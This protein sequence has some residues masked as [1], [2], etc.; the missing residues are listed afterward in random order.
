MEIRGNEIERMGG[1]EWVVANGTGGFALGTVSGERMRGYHGLLIAA[2][3]PPLGRMMLV[4]GVR[5]TVVAGGAQFPLYT[6]RYGDGRS[7]PGGN[8][9]IERFRM[10][11]GLPVWT[12][13]AGG[14]LVEK[15][16]G[17][18]RDAAAAF[19]RWTLIEGDG[20]DLEIRVLVA[21]RGYH[22]VSSGTERAPR[23]ETGPDRLLV[24]F[25]DA[26]PPLA[27]LAPRA[28][29][30]E[31]NVEWER[32]LHLA[33]EEYRGL[34]C[35]EDIPSV[36]P[37]RF[38]IERGGRADLI[39]SAEE[40]VD[41]DVD[42][43]IR[44][45]RD[46]DRDLMERGASLI[47]SAGE[48]AEEIRALLRA[49]DSFLAR[50]PTPDDPDG[51][52]VIAGYPWFTD[53][54]RDTMIALPGLA[55]ATGRPEIA[56]SILRVFARHVDAG[57]IPN[58]FPDKGE[59]PEYNTIDATLW[60][61]EAARAY[62]EATGDDALLAEL[63]PVLGEI[64]DRHVYGTRHGIGVDHADGLLAGGEPGVQLTWMD[65]K[66]GDWVVT[67]R[68]GK[69]VEI[70]ALWVNALRSMEGFAERLGGDGEG[71]A[72]LAEE[73]ER[74]FEKFWNEE[75]GCLF[76]LID[77]PEGNDPSVRPNQIFAASLRYSPLSPDWRRAVVDAVERDLLT[78]YGLR[79]LAPDHPEYRPR[80][81]GD[82]VARDGAYHQGTVWSWLIG[83]FVE[84]HLKAHGDKKK[85]RAF[86]DPL[87]DYVGGRGLGTVAEIFDGDPPHEPRGCPAQAW[88]VAEV[89][90]AWMLTR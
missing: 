81:G 72:R 19:V 69:P 66:A 63:F 4:P 40:R 3:R 41:A 2:L 49:A 22:D 74:S 65:A 11:E 89:L 60:F 29:S 59:R 47:V 50:R 16:I 15:R 28:S 12:F 5:E 25:D 18:V 30:V 64:V 7:E 53:W 55:L 48:R 9:R 80:Y 44:A 84:A 39:L 58:R 32:D 86:L 77:G 1:A 33:V 34:P 61:F 83:P 6:N 85:A 62:V 87:L 51:K 42:G 24:T 52:T 71:F 57:M 54:G 26:A 79:S 73:A 45:I 23:M 56:A 82:R 36:G 21:H 90:R 20:I 10:E 76:D 8:R 67:P 70:N 43:A 68:I 75:T 88:S 27:I 78:P 31:D 38:R 37:I 35:R 46:H 17:L 13:R 14:A